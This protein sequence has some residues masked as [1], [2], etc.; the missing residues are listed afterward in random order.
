MNQTCD[1][2]NGISFIVSMLGDYDK[3]TAVLTA[4]VVLSIDLAMSRI[5]CLSNPISD[6]T[7]SRAWPRL[8][9]T[10]LFS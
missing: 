4:E 9:H 10:G 5:F 1:M 7:C 8:L 3:E 2:T 6:R